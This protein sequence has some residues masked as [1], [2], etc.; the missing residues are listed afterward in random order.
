[1]EKELKQIK[2]FLKSKCNNF[3]ISKSTNSTYYD[4]KHEVINFRVRVAD[5][6]ST[7]QG[8]QL[9]II[10]FANSDNLSF[11]FC[12]KL[13]LIPAEKSLSFIKSLLIIFPY[14]EERNNFTNKNYKTLKKSIEGKQ[15]EIHK[16]SKENNKLLNKI[17]SQQSQ[18]KDL[19]E[20][21]K[22]FNRLKTLLNEIK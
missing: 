3:T 1:M 12:N 9:E 2:R 14:I 18:I 13:F 16:L 19:A 10:G 4:F 21:L 6:P 11:R 15:D 17:N 5:H 7:S 8:N 22:T 20:N